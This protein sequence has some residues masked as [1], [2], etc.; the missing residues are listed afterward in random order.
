MS[1]YIGQS[2]GTAKRIA[3]NSDN[4]VLEAPLD[5][6]QYVRKNG[7]WD[8]FEEDQF[9]KKTDLVGYIKTQESISIHV[10]NTNIQDTIDSLDKYISGE[11]EIIVDEEIDHTV[12]I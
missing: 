3:S 2:G 1:R 5:G 6:E 9:V 4:S 12:Y 8:L 10:N 11:V 7:D